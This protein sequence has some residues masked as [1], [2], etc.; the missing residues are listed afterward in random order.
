MNNWGLINFDDSDATFN[1]IVHDLSEDEFTLEEGEYVLFD[2]PEELNDTEIIEWANKNELLGARSDYF[3]EDGRINFDSLR[4]LHK[5]DYLERLSQYP[6]TFTSPSS[7]AFMFFEDLG[8]DFPHDI[9]ISV[10]DGDSPSHDW[11][12]VVVNGI[13]S[14]VKLQLFLLENN[15][16]VNFKYDV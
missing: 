4:K 7:R 11:Q 16:K 10:I 14:V 1:L 2:E 8:F 15:I 5:N 12:G 3:L 9:D 13:S 6:A